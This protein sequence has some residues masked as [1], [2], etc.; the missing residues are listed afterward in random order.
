MRYEVSSGN[1]RR[2]PEQKLYLDEQADQDQEGAL[3]QIFSGQSGGHFTLLADFIG[4][5]LGVR[6][7]T[8]DYKADGKSR[9]LTV[10]NLAAME[11]QAIEGGDGSEVIISNNPLG[12]VPGE[13]MV[14]AK[15]S[16]LTYHDHGMDWDL[17]GMNAYYSPFAYTGP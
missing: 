3:T 8:I 2:S 16:K 10:G 14:V 12:V 7:A 5:V 15:A 6:S 11:V 17:S 13:P 9:S 1:A 4:E